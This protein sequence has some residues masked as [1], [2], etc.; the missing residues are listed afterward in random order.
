MS[1][2]SE[3][4]FVGQS[5]TSIVHRA[6]GGIIGL[7][8]VSDDASR[9][10]VFAFPFAAIKEVVASQ[11]FALPGAYVLSGNG[12]VYLGESGQV[13]RRLLEHR[14]DPEKNFARE[15]FVVAAFNERW[16]DKIPAVYLQFRLTTTAESAGFVRVLRGASPRMLDLPAWRRAPLERI[17]Q[18]AERLLFD[19]GCRA[20]HA[21]YGATA[22]IE[23]SN[24][25]PLAGAEDSTGDG[26]RH[27]WHENRRLGP[28]R[29]RG[30]RVGIWRHLGAGL[31][32]RRKLRGRGGL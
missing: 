5:S 30:V 11:A 24:I 8:E 25:I 15:V 3:P 23:Q 16:C 1:A 31:S 7:R 20:F 29:H 21:A 6:N 9:L 22:Q 12:T 32:V 17:G 4:T 18:D 10:S 27:R 28:K 26:G 2:N 14:E 13:G 19:A